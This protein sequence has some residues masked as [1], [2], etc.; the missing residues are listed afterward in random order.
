M[1]EYVFPHSSAIETL[2]LELSLLR[3]LHHRNKNQHHLQP[4]FKYLSILKRTLNLLLENA[5]SQFLL[6]KL[7]E[8]VI[9][10]AWESFS[11]IVARGEFITLGLVLCASVARIAY[12]LD[13]VEET[14]DL[15]L[16]GQTVE[17]E[18]GEDGLGEIVQRSLLEEARI[19]IE[20]E[21]GDLRSLPWP[22][23]P[24]AVSGE[25]NDKTAQL[26]ELQ[27]VT[28]N[29]DESKIGDIQPPLKRKRRKR[30]QDE[31]DILFAGL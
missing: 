29:G 11:R 16:E 13:G 22:S 15:N 4:F 1:N 9:P 12:C 8:R 10:N 18:I 25:G 31:I 14:G 23:S 7:R 26:Q 2:Q 17:L 30:G 27:P 5:D 21:H 3:I 6:Q 24:L 20:E 28:V 19:D